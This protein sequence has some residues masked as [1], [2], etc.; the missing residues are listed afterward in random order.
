M[1]T[2]SHPEISV[3]QDVTLPESVH[4]VSSPEACKA[5]SSRSLEEMARMLEAVL[6]TMLNADA[7]VMDTAY[8]TGLPPAQA[9]LQNVLPVAM[10]LPPLIKNLRLMEKKG[11]LRWTSDA[12]GGR[13]TIRGFPVGGLDGLLMP[14]V[15]AHVV[16][17]EG[18]SQAD[19]H[20]LKSKAISSFREL[21]TDK[22]GLYL[23]P[24]NVASIGLLDVVDGLINRRETVVAKVSEKVTFLGRHYENHLRPF[25][26]AGALA[27]V[28][29][30]PAEGQALINLDQI[31]HIHVTGSIKTA[32]KIDSI[33]RPDQTFTSELGGVTPAIVMPDVRSDKA[34]RDA[35]KQIVFGAFSNNGQQ[36]VSFQWVL[37]PKSIST[38]LREEVTR[39]VDALKW[40]NP[41]E[42]HAG[43]DHQLGVGPVIDELAAKHYEILM[44]DAAEAG[45]TI[46]RRSDQVSGRLVPPT[47]ISGV[48]PETNFRL[49]TEEAFLPLVGFVDYP[50]A[51]FAEHVL[52]NANEMPGDLGA[53]IITTEHDNPAIHDMAL[54]LKHGAVGINAHPGLAFSMPV[55]WGAGPAHESGKGFVHNHGLIPEEAVVKSVIVTKLGPKGVG[56]L[57][58]WEDPWLMNVAGAESLRIGQGLAKFII[59]MSLGR[60]P[61]A[62]IGS[63]GMNF[64]L[65]RRE[66]KRRFS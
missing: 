9:Y 20:A 52:E 33:R 37:A 10:G 44:A 11:D 2:V 55:P 49:R 4:R 58:R 31:G 63:Q 29:G 13:T 51:G 7:F 41:P 1:T 27:I 26:D 22:A 14:G 50:E 42:P 59:N 6:E 61:G 16:L 35:A 5:W 43:P 36:C 64:N 24:F 45:V 12:F 25:I 8:H 48:T 3:S 56:P 66:L 19:V 46:H 18:I 23:T 28:Q 60:Y 38:R 53:S 65:F 47:V 17:K 57:I 34:I 40:A 32:N 21:H 62:V 54:R 15:T 39:Q 30:G